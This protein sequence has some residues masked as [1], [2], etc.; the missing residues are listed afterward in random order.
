MDSFAKSGT[1][2]KSDEYLLR[3]LGK[4][5]RGF[6][7]AVHN[8]ID[9]RRLREKLRIGYI[10]QTCLMNSSWLFDALR[11]PV[12]ETISC[13]PAVSPGRHVGDVLSLRTSQN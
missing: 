2:E 7:E 12:T 13:S 5:V 4:G 9:T 8:S 10:Q 1:L 3:K 6:G 11:C